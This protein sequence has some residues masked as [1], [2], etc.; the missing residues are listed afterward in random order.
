MLCISDVS[1]IDYIYMYT[2]LTVET[3]KRIIYKKSIQNGHKLW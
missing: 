1:Y 3:T 2:L